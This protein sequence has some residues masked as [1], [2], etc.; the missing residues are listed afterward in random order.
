MEKIRPIEQKL[1]YQIEKLLRTGEREETEA[2]ASIQSKEDPLRFKPTLSLDTNESDEDEE[3]GMT[4]S[5]FYFFFVHFINSFYK[6]KI[7]T[8]FIQLKK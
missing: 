8:K 3:D 1:R 6:K 4:I 2:S 5:Y 7:K